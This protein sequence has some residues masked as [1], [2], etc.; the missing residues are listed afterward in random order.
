M[1]IIKKLLKLP[2]YVKFQG[3]TFVLYVY[4][5]SS[6]EIR[7]AYLIDSCD[8]D[9]KHFKDF[10]TIKSFKNPFYN[11]T[12]TDFLNIYENIENVKDF[13]KAINQ[14]KVFLKKI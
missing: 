4:K 3:I 11:L 8:K 7:I 9:S 10:S 12:Y 5:N 13:K 2:K 6:T 1:D 14:C